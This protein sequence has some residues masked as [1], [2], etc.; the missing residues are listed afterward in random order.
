MPLTGRTPRDCYEPFREHVSK[1]LCETL[2][3]TAVVAVEPRANTDRFTLLLRPPGAMI[4]LDTRL[5]RLHLHI[6][7]ALEAE[8][9]GRRKGYIL[10]T[11]QYWYRLHETADL[12][13]EALIR[14]EYDRDALPKDAPRPPRNHVQMAGALTRAGGDAL[15]LNKLHVPT[16][17]VLLE[18]VIRFLIADLGVKPPCGDKWPGILVRGE[19][20][21]RKSYT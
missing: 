2:H 15:D 13:K 18:A 10:R 3:A 19:E 16:G 20:L 4:P 12:R 9:L 8:R 6:A 5:G 11:R 17:W 21:F 7:Q 14:W 1:V